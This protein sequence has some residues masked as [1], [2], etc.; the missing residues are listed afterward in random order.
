MRQLLM[1]GFY[2]EVYRREPRCRVYANDVLLDEFNITHAPVKQGGV[3]N[4]EQLS[5][6]YFGQEYIRLKLATPFLKYIEFDDQ[7]AQEVCVKIEIQNN[8]NNYSN[9]FMSK[10][11]R[12]M[13]PFMYLSS[14]KIL[15]NIDDLK[16]RWKFSKNYRM[17]TKRDLDTYY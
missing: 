13:I 15:N 10:Y 4:G 12:V 7:N 11:T 9:G 17:H 1:L 6:Q 16:D 2:C 14:K 8:D 5:P 3:V